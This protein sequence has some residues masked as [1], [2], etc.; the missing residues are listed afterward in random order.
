[1]TRQAQAIILASGDGQ[2][3]GGSIPKQFLK[4][5]G[6]TVLEHT[7]ERFERN[8]YVSSII[9]V[10]NPAYY[11]FVRE[12]LLKSSY[13]KVTRLLKG[14][15]TRQESSRIGL[16]A[17]SE[18]PGYVLTHD[19]VRPFVSDHLITAVL[20]ALED[21]DAVDVAI[22]SADTIIQTDDDGLIEA[23]PERRHLRRGQ[24]PQGFKLDLIRKAYELYERDPTENVTDDCGLIVRY[25]LGKVFVV[26]GE[27]R[28][29][30]ITYPEDVYLADKL[31]QINAVSIIDVASR[32]GDALRGK[33]VVV[34]GAS[35]GI[36]REL[37]RRAAEL[38]ARV[39]G[40]SR[41]TGV[42]VARA[43]QVEEALKRA[44]ESEGGIDFVVNTAG[45][46]NAARLESLLPEEITNQIETNYVGSI[47]VTRASLPYLRET[48]GGIV[49]FT[50]SSYTRGR[51]MLSVYSSTKAAIVNF[52]QAMAEELYE[53]GVR[54]CA[55]NPERTKTRLRTEN[56]G[57]EPEG[58]LLSPEVVADAVVDVMLSDVTGQVIDVKA[59]AEGKPG[60]T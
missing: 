47:N 51:A 16:D 32:G 9:L 37:A 24:T 1:M 5:A 33:R 2:R 43:E 8:Q 13:G 44:S 4:I 53:D 19:A 30:K 36:G 12:M 35:R 26:E 29:I 34:F 42:D 22:P 41:S 45:V 50:S 38:G 20:D 40:F 7:I 10:V 57:Q 28:N 14:G 6:R 15:R 39:T 48:R 55:V 59:G 23:I 49:L 58:T 3:F 17:C 46:L 21:H 31:F 25:G 56:F 52:V 54:I 60:S 27:E 11:E 18:E